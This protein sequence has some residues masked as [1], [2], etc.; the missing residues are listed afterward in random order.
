MARDC[1]GLYQDRPALFFEGEGLSHAWTHRDLARASDGVAAGLRKKGLK[2][3]DR[4]VLAL[5]NGP[6]FPAVFFG[7]IKAGAIP[8]P[9]SATLKPGEIAFLKK[10]SGARLVLSEPA[11]A[12]KF[13]S[14]PGPAVRVPR[15]RG[16]DP[17]FWLYTSGTE[18]RPKA[19]IHAH[20]SIP[21]HDARN[22]LWLDLKKH[23]VVFNTS[24][25]NWSYALT[26]G[27]ADVLR[28]GVTSVVFSGRPEPERLLE[29]VRK[30]RVTIFL[31]VPGL[32]R[33]LTEYFEKRPASRRL[34]RSV[35]VCL[36]A[37]EKLP[38]EIR[39]RFRSATGLTIREGLGMT[40]HSV[41]LVQ[42][43]GRRVVEGSCGR[44][45]PGHRVAIL[46]E[47]LSPTRPGEVGI[48]ASHRSCPGLMSGYHRG[49]KEGKAAFRKGW[50]L[51]GDLAYRDEQGNYFFI[52]RRDDVI[53]AGGYRI[54]PM[55]VENVL[56]RHPAVRGSAAVGV[57]IAPG[58]TVVRG[59]VILKKGRKGTGTLKKS[60]LDF[61]RRNLAP[62][63]APRE[64]VFETSLP[65]TSTGKLIRKRFRSA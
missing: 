64:I 55:E 33:R 34:F 24:A 48:L 49:L 39:T 42:P 61:A 21:A 52:G 22:R 41:Y 43:K 30:R 32:F 7:A 6:E 19:V 50:F 53:T 51:S 40:E 2:R 38:A 16:D 13:M 1:A 63:K 12:R 11:R 17:A 18:G 10:D 58:K 60:V 25:L 44:P 4:L 35:R 57:E 28:R 23:D 31:S 46:R 37:G 20:R 14:A 3:G 5:P 29:V 8:I 27:L 9:V 47:D 36:S 15:T 59:H 45:L 54:S 62:Y 56:N 26:C 65:R